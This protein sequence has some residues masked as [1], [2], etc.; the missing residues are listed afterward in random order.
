[1]SKFLDKRKGQGQES[2]ILLFSLQ[3]KTAVCCPLTVFSCV[4]L[5]FDA[6]QHACWPF[7]CFEY[8]YFIFFPVHILVGYVSISFV[9]FRIQIG[10][11]YFYINCGNAI[12]VYRLMRQ[13]Q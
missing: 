4:F 12:N 13:E 3:C 10:A 11:L 5:Y 6:Q 2:G 9:L 7:L 1:M 8:F